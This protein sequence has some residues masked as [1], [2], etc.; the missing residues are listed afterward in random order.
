MDIS[1]TT[2]VS[3]QARQK[4]NTRTIWEPVVESTWEI[5]F[6]IFCLFEGLH[7]IQGE[8]KKTWKKC[9]EG[10][11]DIIS[12]TV[13]TTAAFDIVRRAED[14]LCNTRKKMFPETTQSYEEFVALLFNANVLLER[15]FPDKL[16]SLRIAAFE[17]FV[18]RPTAQT[19]GKFLSS[20]SEY[21]ADYTWPMPIPHMSATFTVPLYI[22]EPAEIQQRETDDLAL[23]QLL[24]D[25]LLRDWVKDQP[26][27]IEN[28]QS[29]FP[30]FEDG[31]TFI[32]RDT[33][34]TGETSVT[35]IFASR[36]LLDIA[37]EFGGNFNGTEMLKK[38]NE[39]ISKLFQFEV[40]KVDGEKY[41]NTSG[42][43]HWMPQ[44][45]KAITSIWKHFLV[46]TKNPPFRRFKELLLEY[47]EKNPR[48]GK[49]ST[50]NELNEEQRR[51]ME[52]Q[53]QVWG[54]RPSPAEQ[55][56]PE[57]IKPNP[58]LDFAVNHNPLYVGTL[59]LNIAVLIE[60]VAISLANRQLS[61][62]SSAHLYNA[63]RQLDLIQGSWPEMEKV[64]EKDVDSIFAGDIPTTP[65]DMYSRLKFRLNGF[66]IGNGKTVIDKKGRWKIR[67]S[68]GAQTLREF[69]GKDAN[70]VEKTL[71]ELDMQIQKREQA[72]L[73]T[74]S[75]R[76]VG[77]RRLTPL[78]FLDALEEYMPIAVSDITVDYISLTRTCNKLMNFVRAA[79]CNDLGAEVAMFQSPDDTYDDRNATMVLHSL[80][81]TLDASKS[82]GR[83]AKD[84]GSFKGGPRLIVAGEVLEKFRAKMA[85][86]E[87]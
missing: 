64:I 70:N 4:A 36:V 62:F 9:K 7:R 20:L 17:E 61:I 40:L 78:K 19:L 73:S 25:I 83:M 77:H 47:N 48:S 71:S 26:Q 86:S 59:L 49:F 29:G 50:L 3:K 55:P 2:A 37:Q 53:L 30:T 28:M 14:D 84:R 52:N 63:L 43:V 22:L 54:L 45:E 35:S 34:R 11:L 15:V 85:E 69:F 76:S 74:P 44:D 32:I 57:P 31:F 13:V 68:P 38:E 80:K 21:G 87:L 82:Q 81:N 65:K 27:V 41:L 18:Y 51:D 58:D 79:L 23:S 46:H 56:N 24:L 42:G 10:N 39:R 1:A 66:S 16:G 12:A 75:K 67:G 8:L 6:S 33:W 72:L 60:E 5:V